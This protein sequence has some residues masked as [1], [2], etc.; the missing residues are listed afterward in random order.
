MK[1]VVKVIAAPSVPGGKA[2]ALCTE[3]GQPVGKQVSCVVE[4]EV[5]EIGVIT[6]RFYIDGEAIRFASNDD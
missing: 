6:V 5:R 3:E 2:L 1:L 4:N